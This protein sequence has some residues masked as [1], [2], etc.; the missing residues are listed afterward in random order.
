MEPH[1]APKGGRHVNANPASLDYLIPTTVKVPGNT[2]AKVAYPPG[3]AFKPKFLSEGISVY[4]GAVT[5][6]V[7][8]PKGSLNSMRHL[9]VQIE[10]QACTHEICLPPATISVQSG[11]S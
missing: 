7:E 3:T 5:L 10:V 11:E 4:E 6:K 8:L 1:R 9:P 2:Q